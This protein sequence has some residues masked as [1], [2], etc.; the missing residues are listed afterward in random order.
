MSK[1]TIIGV[2]GACYDPEALGLAFE[3]QGPT[4]INAYSEAA[5]NLVD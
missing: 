5:T 3:H 1:N 2:Y 4:F